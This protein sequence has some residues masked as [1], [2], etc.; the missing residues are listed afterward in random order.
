[1]VVADDGGG[2]AEGMMNMR[3]RPHRRSTN[4][5]NVDM[6]E[7]ECFIRHRGDGRDAPAAMTGGIC[8]PPGARGHTVRR[9]GSLR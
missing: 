4:D 5:I 3:I 6:G 8:E 1:M 9:F 7:S 2:D